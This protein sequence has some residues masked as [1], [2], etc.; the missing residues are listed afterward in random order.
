MPDLGAVGNL[1]SAVFWALAAYIPP[2]AKDEYES[3]DYAKSLQNFQ[4]HLLP[5]T[6]KLS[7]DFKKEFDEIW[8]QV[9]HKSH[10]DARGIS[11]PNLAYDHAKQSDG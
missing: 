2:K 6:G 3:V 10:P 9:S 1:V 4:K 8:L 5:L 11:D 7:P